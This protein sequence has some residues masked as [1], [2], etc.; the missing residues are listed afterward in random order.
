MK[1][2][3]IIY[4]DKSLLVVNKP[5]GILTI[6]TTKEK[7]KTLYHEV[8]EYL[9]RKNQKVFIVNRLDKDTSG[10]VMF[11]KNQN[12]KNLL[13]S[14]WENTIRKYYAVVIG[15]INKP[16]TIE[17]YLFEGKD[18][19]TYI[20]NDKTKGKK[21]ITK[22]VPINQTS[23]YTLLDIEIKTG[24][25]NQIRV[26]LSSINHPIIGD[27]KYNAKKNPIGRLGLHSYYLEFTHPKTKQIIKLETKIPKEFNK[28]FE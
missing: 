13:Q 26:A 16:T 24:R 8:F 25:K 12:I 19:K 5:S 27:K 6:A 3:D 21:A 11:A 1:K 28:I 23:V 15:K 14:N 20:T 22:I 18:L 9:H 7:E 2:L 17:Q 4:E 10:L